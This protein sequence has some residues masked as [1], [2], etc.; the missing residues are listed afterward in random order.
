MIHTNYPKCI[1]IGSCAILYKEDRFHVTFGYKQAK[2]NEQ[3][4]VEEIEEE[5]PLELVDE[6]L[7]P[8]RIAGVSHYGRTTRFVLG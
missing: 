3:E 7:L 4:H 6:E 8:S 5:T 2:N 1:I